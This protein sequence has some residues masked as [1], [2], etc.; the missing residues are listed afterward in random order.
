[1]G[2]LKGLHPLLTADLLHVLRSMGHGDQLAIVDVNFPAAST[3]AATSSGKHVLLA[4]ANLPDTLEAVCSVLPLDFFVE[5]PARHMAP[6]EGVALPDSG[7]EVIA[8]AGAAVAAACPG[9]TLQPLERFA[10]YEE[11]KT[12]FAVVQTHE[13]RPYGNVL[14]RK[15]VVGPDGRD[16]KP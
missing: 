9:T 16:L 4:G 1:M 13:R 3:A 10:F 8:A 11:A 7:G 5:Q 2:L 14:L 15:G 6:Q 12:C